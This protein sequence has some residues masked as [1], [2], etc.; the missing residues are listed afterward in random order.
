[1]LEDGDAKVDE[2]DALYMVGAA[3]A[4]ISYL[5]GKGRAAGLIDAA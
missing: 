4:F 3:A 5:I 1:M 2:V